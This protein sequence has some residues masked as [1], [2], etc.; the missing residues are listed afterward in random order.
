MPSTE[1]APLTLSVPNVHNIKDA[2][3]GLLT[4]NY[5]TYNPVTVSYRINNGAW[6]DQP[7]PFGACYTQNGIVLC[8]AKTIAIPV[9]L[10]DVRPGTNTI[11]FASSDATAI[12]NVDLVLQGA[13]GIPKQQETQVHLPIVVS[14]SR[15]SV[16]GVPVEP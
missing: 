13:G 2:V 6:H 4:F 1:S 10:S 11:Q 9:S 3:G 16:R 5:F 15:T 12:A 14:L 8:G 7:W